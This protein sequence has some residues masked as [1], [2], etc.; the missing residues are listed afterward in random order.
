MTNGAGK[1]AC[2]A[3]FI[4]P[5][6]PQRS[7]SHRAGPRQPRVRCRAW[8]WHRVTGSGWLTPAVA[9]HSH[10]AG[11]WEEGE[12]VPLWW[13]EVLLREAG[14]AGGMQR[15]CRPVPLQLGGFLSIYT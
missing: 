13:G 8:L 12:Q 15:C 6:Q 2:E 5:L 11:S 10:R 7:T 4:P 3:P 14:G 1:L 9:T